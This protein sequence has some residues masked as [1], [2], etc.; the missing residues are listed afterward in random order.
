MKKQAFNPYLPSYE[1]IP[2]GEPYVFGERVYVYGS[3]DKFAGEVFCQNDYVCWSAPIDKLYD[4]KYEGVIYRK[5]QDPYNK[6]GSRSLWAPDVQLG[7]DGRYYL[8]YALDGHG[9]ISVAICDTP[10]GEYQYYGS[11]KYSNGKVVGEEKGDIFQFDPAIFIDDDQR[12]FLYSGIGPE[13]NEKIDKWVQGRRYE[14]AYCIE[15]EKDMLTVK[16]EPKVIIPK[17]GFAE[18]TGYEGH[19][20]FEASSMRKIGD[21][22]YFIYSSFKSH[23]LC[24]ARSNRP[25]G[26]FK[27]GGTIISNGDIGLDATSVVEGVNYTGNN[28][29][30]IINIKGQWYVFYHR[31]TNRHTFSRQ[32]C[33]EKITIDEKGNIPQVEMTSCGLNEGPLEGKG[34]Y[35]TYIACNLYS[36]EGAVFYSFDLK[37]EYENHP[38]FTQSGEDREQNGDQ[39][40]SGMRDGSVAGFKYFK[41]ED[42]TKITIEVRGNAV[43]IVS[44]LSD[45][46]GK[47][48]ASIPVKA[49]EGYSLFSSELH[50][51]EEISALF[52]K[53]HGSGVLDFKTFILE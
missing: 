51:G 50:A 30:S 37:E 38:A 10:V 42:T 21:T 26:D 1:Y 23:E 17:V 36:K 48:I 7:L 9:I 27:Y 11:V 28:H 22:Y 29:G 46:E 3:H 49:E 31:Q 8:Y 25:D 2:D 35:A 52:F 32:G 14:G 33:A 40:I 39:Y 41:L 16:A 15:L 18:G 45:R 13:N 47:E 20:F 12:I 4:W 5:K 53:Y 44:V 43:G 6:D 24:Y 34:S 19:E